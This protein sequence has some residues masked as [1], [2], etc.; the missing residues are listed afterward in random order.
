MLPFKLSVL[1]RREFHHIDSTSSKEEEEEWEW[2]ESR[3]GIETD[4][5]MMCGKEMKFK[6]DAIA[7]EASIRE[8]S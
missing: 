8:T 3:V 7:A 6:C 2:E 4:V 5:C 1:L